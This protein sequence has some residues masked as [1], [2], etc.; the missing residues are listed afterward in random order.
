MEQF[1]NEQ[2]IEFI[3][4]VRSAGWSPAQ[5]ARVLHLSKASVSR[6]LSGQQTP[7]SH[8]L[9]ALRNAVATH[10]KKIFA[11]LEAPGGNL[12]DAPADQL[13][14]T[15]VFKILDDVR[16]IAETD[17]DKARQLGEIAKTYRQASGN[18]PNLR[19]E[20]GEKPTS[21]APVP[22]ARPKSSPSPRADGSNEKTSKPKPGIGK[23]HTPQPGSPAQVP[24]E[25]KN[26]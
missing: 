17:P 20:T 5:T 16:V 6:I 15:E 10:N 26:E 12:T 21:S 23:R 7:R 14:S 18:R 3:A 2:Q 25:P 13:T 19:K 9:E 1:K 24:T 22:D 8:T 4:L 11:P